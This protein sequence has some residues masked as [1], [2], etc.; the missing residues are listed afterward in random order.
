MSSSGRPPDDA[1]GTSDC[2]TDG[3]AKITA[4]PSSG[5]HTVPMPPTMI[6]ATYCTDSSTLHWS[7]VTNDR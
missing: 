2:S 7:G 3:M 4:E 1:C 5:P 6:A